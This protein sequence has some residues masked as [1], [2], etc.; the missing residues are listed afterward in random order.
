MAL[1]KDQIKEYLSSTKK[2]LLSTVTDENKPDI[3][4]LGGFATDGFKLYFSSLRNSRKV[5]QIEANPHVAVYFEAPNQQFPNYINATVYGKAKEVTCEKEI[6][7]AITLIKEKLPHFQWSSKKVIYLVKPQQVK[8][9]NSSG[10]FAQDKL[11]IV[12]FDNKAE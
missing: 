6:E 8:I 2:I 11:Q 1:S 7:K 10:E 4:I 12:D 3:R 9:Y 5:S